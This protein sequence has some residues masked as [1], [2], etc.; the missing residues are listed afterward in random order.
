M[1]GWW[2]IAALALL[3]AGVVAAVVTF[4]HPIRREPRRR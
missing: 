4:E 3:G 2:S 1:N